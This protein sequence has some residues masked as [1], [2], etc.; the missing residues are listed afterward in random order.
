MK[1]KQFYKKV[2]R[3]HAAVCQ[4]RGADAASVFS[5][6]VWKGVESENQR[7]QDRSITDMLYSRESGKMVISVGSD[8]QVWD[9]NSLR[10]INLFKPHQIDVGRVRGT[11][12]AVSQCGKF[13]I[14]GMAV[15]HQLCFNKDSAV[16]LNIS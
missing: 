3:T 2:M 10:R 11:C 7:H 4:G 16:R 1:C 13:L 12:F 6:D 8:V 9:V 14:F 5:V 15:Q